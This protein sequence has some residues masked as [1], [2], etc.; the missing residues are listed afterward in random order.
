MRRW[1]GA[2]V[3]LVLGAGL[4]PS[5]AAPERGPLRFRITLSKE[6]AP[7]GASG[8][9]FVLMTS[10]AA[11]QPVLRTGF[12]PGATW[13][14]AMEVAHLAPGRTLEFN[15]DLKAFPQPFSTAKPG[16]YQCMALLD[17]DHSYARNNQDAGDFCGP[18][19]AAAGLRPDDTAPVALSLDRV[20]AS[21]PAPIDTDGVKLAELESRLLSDFWGRAIRVQAGV[22]LPPGYEKDP[23]RRYPAVYHIHGFGGDHTSAWRS[24]PRHSAQITA[25]EAAPMVHVYLNGSFPTGHHEFA[26]SANNGPWG[27]ALTREFIP[28]LEGRFRLVPRPTARFLTGHSSGGWSSLWLQVTYP[29]FFGGTWS[30]APDPVDL[31]SFTGVNVTPASEDNVYRTADGKPRNLVRSGGREIASLE[32]FA[33]QEDVQGEYGGQMASFDAVWSPKGPGGRPMPLFNRETGEQDPEV[34]KAWQKYDIRA[35]LEKNWAALGPKLAGKVTVICGDEDTFHL[36]EAVKLLKGFF[37]KV[38][39]EA[40]CELVPGRDHGTLFRPH[41]T[42]PKGLAAR[43]DQEMWASFQARDPDGKKAQAQ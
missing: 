10:S 41:D 1:W 11:P 24:G 31:R 28:Y 3:P 38:K 26:D 17:P 16:T 21:R 36:D 30:T 9:L 6:T 23:Q 7:D 15:P 14:A 25:G 27:A 22:V 39:A 5:A 43:I 2:V 32:E 18:V 42:Y 37:E 20:T 8:R 29:E 34:Q 40:V 4:V 33:K 13:I 35:V 12:V 19:V